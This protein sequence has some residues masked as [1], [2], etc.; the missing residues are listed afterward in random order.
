MQ[1]TFKPQT[2]E[3]MNE[4]LAKSRYEKDASLLASYIEKL[5]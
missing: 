2:N 3:K 5:K 1:C 4:K